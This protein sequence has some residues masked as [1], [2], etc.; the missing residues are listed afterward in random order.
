[1]KDVVIPV[2]LVHRPPSCWTAE[3]EGFCRDMYTIYVP[4][5]RSPTDQRRRFCVPFPTTICRQGPSL[6]LPTMLGSRSQRLWLLLVGL[7]LSATLTAARRPNVSPQLADKPLVELTPQH[8]TALHTSFAEA[9]LQSG[10]IQPAYMDSA[11]VK[12][13]HGMLASR[14][15]NSGQPKGS[16]KVIQKQQAEEEAEEYGEEETG[17]Y[18]SKEAPEG[19]E[20]RHSSDDSGDDH[21]EM[22]ER[23]PPSEHEEERHQHYH[24][25][26]EAESVCLVEKLAR[27]CVE[28][29]GAAGGPAGRR[30][31]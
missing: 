18:H 28:F 14:Q 23:Q 12:G 9:L 6:A 5:S 3:T 31:M 1:M 8:L 11:Y 26:I 17:G 15:A 24:A 7:L 29:G 27:D 25:P 2:I 22:H 20:E 4:D 10:G 16:S 19:H 30:L 21:T 13:R